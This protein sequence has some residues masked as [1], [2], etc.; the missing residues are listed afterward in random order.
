VVNKLKTLKTLVFLIFMINSVLSQSAEDILEI[1]I[2]KSLELNNSYYKFRVESVIDSPLVPMTGELYTRGEKYFVDTENI[3]QIYDGETMFTIVHENQEILIGNFDMSL[4]SLTPYK[5][6][7][8][9]LEDHSLSVITNSKKHII[10][11]KRIN[12]NNIIYFISINSINHSIEKIEMKDT[13][14]DSIIN[15]FLTLT[16]DYNLSVPESLFKFDINNYENY[17]IVK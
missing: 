6:L 14:S 2:N 10:E 3:D 4:F 8:F 16:Y 13:L 7:N 9:F 12:E 5:I 11:A 1:A 15:S 17:T